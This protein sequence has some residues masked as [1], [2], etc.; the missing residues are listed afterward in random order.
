MEPNLRGDKIQSKGTGLEPEAHPLSL[1][2]SKETGRG[3]EIDGSA[4]ELA[5]IRRRVKVWNSHCGEGEKV[6]SGAT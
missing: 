6:P 5:G 3:A 2:R 4:V 1:E